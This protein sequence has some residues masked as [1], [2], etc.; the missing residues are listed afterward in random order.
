MSDNL[1]GDRRTHERAPLAYR[2]EVS[3]LP[4]ETKKHYHKTLSCQCRDISGGGLSFYCA[5]SCPRD[6]VVRLSIPIDSQDPE[7]PEATTPL[8]VMAKVVWC[9]KIEA[10]SYVVGAQFLNIYEEDFQFLVNYVEAQLSKEEPA[11]FKANKT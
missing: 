9:K 6:T 5:K 11:V 1:T 10:D 2:I 8:D 4:C 7:S 3:M